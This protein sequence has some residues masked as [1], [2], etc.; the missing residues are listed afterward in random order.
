MDKTLLLYYTKD[1]EIMYYSF[2]TK[3]VYIHLAD[4]KCFG[5]KK[6]LTSYDANIISEYI[7][8]KHNI[9]DDN[10]FDFVYN[11]MH[12]KEMVQYIKSSIAGFERKTKLMAIL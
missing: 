12:N 5:K 6:K 9:K 4:S 1:F 11:D 8:K 3:T 2:E 7:S 10:C